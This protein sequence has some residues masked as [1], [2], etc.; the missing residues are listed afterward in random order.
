MRWVGCTNRVMMGKRATRIAPLVAGCAVLG[1]LVGAAHGQI[2]TV[3]TTSG[4]PG[5]TRWVPVTLDPLGI[6]IGA[7]ANAIGFDP[8]NTPIAECQRD[9]TLDKDMQV[10]LLPSPCGGGG[11][12]ACTRVKVLLWEGAT[13]LPSAI[14]T[15]R[16]LYR[17]RIDIPSGATPGT[18]P[19]TLSDASASSPAADARFL[20]LVNGTVT[21]NAPGPGPGC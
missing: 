20:T 19:L 7:T 6:S 1:V 2:L 15:P 5:S 10:T 13:K 3:G 21:V 11:H 16:V 9:P 14:L 12:P 18:Y 17:C 8:A 4:P